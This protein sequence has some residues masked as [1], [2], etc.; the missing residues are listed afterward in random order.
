MLF[1][2]LLHHL[3]TIASIIVPLEFAGL[4][5]NNPVFY[6]QCGCGHWVCFY[7]SHFA[8]LNLCFSDDPVGL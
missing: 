2:F 4:T 7:S 6:E 1:A 5:P 3:L 8:L